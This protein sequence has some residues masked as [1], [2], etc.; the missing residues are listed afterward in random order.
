MRSMSGG[1]GT[2]AVAPPIMPA[3]GTSWH[4]VPHLART[5][6]SVAVGTSAGRAAVA[7][8]ATEQRLG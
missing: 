4:T 7:V 5:Q 8:V 1:S 3:G 2:I 6:A